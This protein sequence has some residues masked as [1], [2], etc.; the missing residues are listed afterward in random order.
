MS[1][2]VYDITGREVV[3]L[4]N[5]KMSA[6]NHIVYWHGEDK[7]GMKVS[8]GIYVYR[9]ITEN[10]SSLIRKMILMK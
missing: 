8:S 2:K 5:E 1:I 3:E 6:G 10:N 9:L 4:I 7:Y